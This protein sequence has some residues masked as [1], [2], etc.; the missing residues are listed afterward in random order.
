MEDFNYEQIYEM[1]TQMNKS[2]K[3]KCLICHFIIETKEMELNCKHQYHNKCI[4][5]I[6][7]KKGIINCPYCGKSNKLNKDNT[8]NICK[9]N[10][11]SGIR[12]GEQCNKKNCG[13]HK[14][15]KLENLDIPA[16]TIEYP[17]ECKSIIKSGI[18]K[19]QQCGRIYCK[20]HN[21]NL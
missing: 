15:T 6:K 7:G 1:I 10:F 19:G 18:K 14:K 17:E 12:K 8:D 21:I 11:K 2:T 13:Y 16:I 4:E 20:Y 5:T 9:W 3:E